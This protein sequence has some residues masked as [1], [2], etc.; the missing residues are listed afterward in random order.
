MIIVSTPHIA[1]FLGHDFSAVLKDKSTCGNLFHGD[2]APHDSLC[3]ANLLG[4][5]PADELEGLLVSTSHQVVVAYFFR[6]TAVGVTLIVTVDLINRC[7]SSL[8]E[9]DHSTGLW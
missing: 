5:P 9:G 1:M 7:G 2:E 8:L 3:V 4:N 6:T